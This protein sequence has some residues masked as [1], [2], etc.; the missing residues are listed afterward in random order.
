MYLHIG[1]DIIIKSQ[2]II[3]IFDI[4][5]TSISKKTI[6]FLNNAQKQ[7]KIINVCNDIPKSFIVLNDKIYI[8][9]ISPLTITKRF[10]NLYNF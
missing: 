1:S 3:G 4:D 7:K 9:Q 2:D 6:E 5:N 8:T 10:N